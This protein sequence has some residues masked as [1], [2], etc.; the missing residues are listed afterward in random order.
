M[1]NPIISPAGYTPAFALSFADAT[2]TAQNV[3]NAAPL[4]VAPAVVGKPGALAGSIAASGQLGP[5]AP[6][7]GTPVYLTLSGTWTGT[8]KVLRSTDGG[9]TRSPLTALGGTWGQF[10]ANACEP[11]WDEGE[12]GAALYLDVA[13]SSG[14]L[15]YRMGQ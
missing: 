1:P 3:S 6:V 5:F 13:L 8:V 9:A 14:T 4:P 7:A 12:A 15:T 11:V 10:T 2:G